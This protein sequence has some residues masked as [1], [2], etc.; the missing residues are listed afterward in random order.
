MCVCVCVCVLLNLLKYCCG[1]A[2]S[3]LKIAILCQPTILLQLLICFESRAQ[4][5]VFWEVVQY[6]VHS[7]NVVHCHCYVYRPHSIQSVW[8]GYVVRC[9]YRRLREKVPPNNPALRKKHFGKKLSR[10]TE[11]MIA[12]CDVRNEGVA[13]VLVESY[14]AM[15]D[16]HALMR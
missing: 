4:W 7:K 3:P 6:N 16:A 14:R 15:E 13:A 9:W 10:L 12:S 5:L 2:L 1:V 11:Q 8:R